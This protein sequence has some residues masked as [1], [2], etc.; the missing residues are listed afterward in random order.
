VGGADTDGVPTLPPSLP[1]SQPP[2]PAEN[3]DTTD[4]DAPVLPAARPIAPAAPVAPVKFDAKGMVES[5]KHA[6]QN[7]AYGGLPKATPES[8]AAAKAL[9]AKA[10]RKRRRNKAVSW[11]V[12]LVMLGGIGAA[13]WFAYQAY[14]DDQ[15]QLDADRDAA[16]ADGSSGAPGA[17]TPLGNQQAVI[18]ALDDVN[19][20]GAAPSAGGLVGAVGDA[21]AAVDDINGTPSVDEQPV[22]AEP[23][24]VPAVLVL[25]DLL[26]E[27]V[28]RLGTRL[29]DQ[30]GYERYVIEDR[31]F[32]ADSPAGYARFL[33]R[34][35]ALP[36]LDPQSPAF[37][38][39]P[40]PQ[41]GQIEVA[42]QRDGDQVIR[43][44]IVSTDP[45][46]HVAYP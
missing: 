36:Q 27:P 34:M 15:D 43:A 12:V 28:V 10:Q 38:M 5:Q 24:P 19:S 9:R 1:P 45:D 14:Q 35:Q 8:I 32:A 23:V 31:Q 21:Q 26:P 18:D 20:A 3:L 25:D 4:L 39:L 46:I 37:T 42:V 13:G 30:D 41:P 29:D 2:Q 33:S 40:A 44:V 22:P 7:P 17:L 6:V 16:Q 11:V